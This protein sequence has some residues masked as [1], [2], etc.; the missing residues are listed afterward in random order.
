MAVD[1]G[2]MHTGEGEIERKGMSGEKKKR[3]E[4]TGYVFKHRNKR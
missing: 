3:R 4:K 1:N 2:T